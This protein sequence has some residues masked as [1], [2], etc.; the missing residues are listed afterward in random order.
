MSEIWEKY[1]IV[2]RAFD[3]QYRGTC[4]L[5]RDHVIKRGDRVARVQRKD[6]P[7]LTVGGVA[8]KLCVAE[9]RT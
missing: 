8:C 5:D 4:T 2:G 6:N 7:M 9:L 1:E 3:S